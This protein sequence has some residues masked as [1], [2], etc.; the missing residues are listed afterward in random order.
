M[1][2][3]RPLSD[4]KNSRKPLTEAKRISMSFE[5]QQ[6]CALLC[7]LFKEGYS[8]KFSVPR[9]S[10]EIC[11]F[12]DLISLN[13]G[14]EFIDIQQKIKEIVSG[15]SK[16]VNPSCQHHV[17]YERRNTMAATVNFLIT[18]IE[19]FGGTF[20]F[21]GT[22]GSN[23]TLK[24]KKIKKINYGTLQWDMQKICEVG[25][26]LNARIKKF[27]KGQK[28]QTLVDISCNQIQF[29]DLFDQDYLNPSAFQKTV[30]STVSNPSLNPSFDQSALSTLVDTP[31][32]NLIDNKNTNVTDEE[33][34]EDNTFME[35]K[36]PNAFIKV[37]DNDYIK[38]ED[39]AMDEFEEI[40]DEKTM[41]EMKEKT[42][43]SSLP[44]A[45]PE[46]LPP[47]SNDVEDPFA[48]S[49]FKKQL[50]WSLADSTE[51]GV[52]QNFCY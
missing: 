14:S 21:K 11:Q 51:G 12:L 15:E 52:L 6:Q 19:G 17:K 20:I 27:F 22:K 4:T 47:L 31:M 25:D 48:E 41:I 18:M 38:V 44:A 34:Q 28:R 40:K 10:S 16:V 39:N 33:T 13:K 26:S 1:K 43:Q 36:V 46:N 50:H 3:H 29:L 42:N 49:S 23:I 35:P 9:K 2:N 8:M 5:G 32:T 7:I 37:E 24:M 45:V 30:N